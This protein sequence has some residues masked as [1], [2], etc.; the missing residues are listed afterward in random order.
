MTRRKFPTSK[1]LTTV[2][3]LG[4]AFAL[5]F[6]TLREDAQL[7]TT[8]KAVQAPLEVTF[9]EEGKTRLKQRYLIAAPVSGTLRRITLQPGERVRAGDALAYI[10]PAS[11]A[12]LDVRSRSQAQAQVRAAQAALTAAQ[13]HTAAAQAAQRLARADLDRLTPLQAAGAA[14]REQLDQ[15]LTRADTTRA[16]LAAA[17]AEER[18]AQER[19]RIAQAQ[20][21]EGQ[22][23][24]PAT[25]ANAQP[26]ALPITAPADGL[27]L[28]RLRESAAPVAA[29]ETLLE[30]GDPAELEIEVEVLS[31]DAVRLTPGMPARIL[32]WGG[33][34]TLHARVRSIEP[35]GFT[36]VSA[37][38][39]QE[40]RTRVILDFDSPR[41]QWAALGDAY[42]VDVEFITHQLPSALQ[43]PGSALFRTPGAGRASAEG[44]AGGWSVYRVDGPQS[45]EPRARATP[46]QIGLRSDT[47][48]QI[49]QGLGEGELV[50]LQPDDQIAEGTRLTI[51]GQD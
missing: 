34:H 25:N 5:V 40:Q 39:V 10:E 15:A 8:A 35:G 4:A 44:D 51:T 46:V 18:S 38:G 33:P 20:L 42:R 47:S 29:G 2:L 28:R 27:V 41:S 14:S 21:L 24:T 32:R 26:R 16:N 48:V 37:L 43:V 50:I 12:L 1:I 7:V 30:I 45:R 19:I 9:T 13:Q 49:T 31:A 17:R 6:F 22:N 3:G 23:P 11:A 36:K